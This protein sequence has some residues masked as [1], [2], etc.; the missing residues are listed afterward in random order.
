MVMFADFLVVTHRIDHFCR[1]LTGINNVFNVP[2]DINNTLNTCFNA[3]MKKQ[4]LIKKK[5]HVL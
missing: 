5:K 4:K 3:D 2:S 1:W